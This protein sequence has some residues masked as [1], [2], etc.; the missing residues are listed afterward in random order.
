MLQSSRPEPRTA[1][2]TADLQPATAELV[3]WGIRRGKV[4]PAA[5]P[6]VS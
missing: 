1:R 5:G 2:A 6:R 3:A 4:L